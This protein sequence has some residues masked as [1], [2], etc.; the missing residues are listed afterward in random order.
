MRFRWWQSIRWRLAFGSALLA[1]LATSF[2]ALTAIFVVNH[3]Y[4]VDQQKNLSQFAR[5]KADSIH[6]YYEQYKTVYRTPAVRLFEAAQSTANSQPAQNTKDQQPQN[7]QLQMIVFDAS[8]APVYP[9]I[10]FASGQQR[11]TTGTRYDIAKAATDQPTPAL[12]I[13]PAA[14]AVSSPQA[15]VEAHATVEARN[16][17]IARTNANRAARNAVLITALQLVNPSI[18]PNDLSKFQMAITN[19]LKYHIPTN[20]TF[21]HDSPVGNAQAFSVRPIFNGPRVI[22]ALFVTMRPTSDAGVFPAFVVSVGFA[23]GI[24]SLIIAVLAVLAAILFSRTITHPLATLANATRVLASGDYSAQ[25]KTKAQGELG[26][27]AHNFNEMAA[28][29]H[30]DVEE[31][32]R[33]EVW[34][35]E[36]IMNITHDLATPLTAI[37]G[38][39]ESLL[40]GVNQSRED[41]EE[42]G[43]II[44]RETLRLRRLVQDLHVMAKVEAGA[45]SPKKKALRVA[46][47][48]D[49]VFAALVSE[50]E[51][52]Q[53]EPVNSVPFNLPAL[54]ADP[55]MLTRVF[56]NLCNNALR[57]TP[58]GGSVT[59]AA[60]VQ[61]D[62]VLV[63]VTD[64][65]E[66]IPEDALPR[67]FE[68]FYRADSS[69]QS[70]TGG[71]GLGLAI[72]QAIVEAHG[73]TTRAENAPGA[74]ARISFTLPSGAQSQML[75]EDTPTRPLSKSV[76]NT[77]L[78]ELE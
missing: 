12:Q 31:L 25:V 8:G 51:R 16:T 47:L 32:R 64:T 65:G 55:D 27:L 49:E 72:V 1:L 37:A 39:G 19:A 11:A 54:Q 42:T 4:G 76:R 68:R 59:I 61:G 44:V 48:V 58:P 9:T 43:S 33:Q 57:H 41:Y 67:V 56:S 7:V 26:E 52:H 45:L 35:R 74:G 66:G 22:G 75:P 40:D 38:L 23:V 70:S 63:T 53:V 46:T 3:Y 2:L 73:G 15:T 10:K 24:A 6:F 14:S 62:F 34:R 5:D 20:D 28:Q 13:T 30:R 21:G 60:V 17:A 18:Q 78:K 71:S 29:L 50:F 36:L 69:R 77:R